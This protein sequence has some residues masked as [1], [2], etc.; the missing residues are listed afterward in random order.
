MCGSVNSVGDDRNS[1]L[2]SARPR[3]DRVPEEGLS[4]QGLHINFFQIFPI[5]KS[6]KF[7]GFVM[8]FFSHVPC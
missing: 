4:I 7:L 1:F 3:G 8:G 2:A 6:K 5:F